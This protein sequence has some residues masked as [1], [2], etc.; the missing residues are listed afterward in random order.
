VEVLA[1]VFL[2]ILLNFVTIKTSS[3]TY[4]TRC[5]PCCAC[6]HNVFEVGPQILATKFTVLKHIVAILEKLHHKEQGSDFES[7]DINWKMP[8]PR[9][10]WSPQL[11]LIVLWLLEAKL[12]QATTFLWKTISRLYEWMYAVFK[13]YWQE[14]SEHAHIRGVIQTCKIWNLEYTQNSN[15]N[16]SSSLNL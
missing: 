14:C 5:S 2:I 6:P 4:A 11:H 1:E 7:L 16:A 12:E 3:K 10:F 9:L 15:L 13:C 8:L